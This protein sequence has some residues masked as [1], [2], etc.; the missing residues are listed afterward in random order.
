[1]IT[2]STR[3][4]ELTGTARI[5]AELH[6]RTVWM[7]HGWSRRNINQLIGSHEIDTLTTQPYFSAIP[8]EIRPVVK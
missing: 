1:M 5:N 6:P 7:N 4:G 3:F 2:I 8:V